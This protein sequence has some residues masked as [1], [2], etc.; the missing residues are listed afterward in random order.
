MSDDALFDSG[1]RLIA[2][3]DVA[4]EAGKGSK[5]DIF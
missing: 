4:T 3:L 1:N 5:A 2:A